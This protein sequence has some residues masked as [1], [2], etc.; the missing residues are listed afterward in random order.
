MSDKKILVLEDEKAISVTIEHALEKE[1]YVVH[2]A[3][4]IAQANELIINHDFDLLIL[5]IGL[6][7]G[8]GLDLCKKVRKKSNVFIFFLTARSEEIDRVLG[9]ELGADDYITKP[10]SPRELVARVKAV[11]RRVSQVDSSMDSKQLGDFKILEDYYQIFFKE[12]GLVLSRYE[13]G[14]L[15]TLILA[16]GRVLSRSQIMEHVW[17]EPD[18]S[19]ERTVDAHIKAIRKKLKEIDPIEVVKTHRGLGYSI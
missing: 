6:P 10:F 5:D 9:L 4:T 12:Q 13:Y 17:E 8:S 19:L 3:T 2:C 15:R 7:D 16:N 1:N 14:I 11:F 18:M